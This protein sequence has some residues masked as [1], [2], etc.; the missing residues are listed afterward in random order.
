MSDIER[1]KTILIATNNPGKAREIEAV[2][3]E[4]AGGGRLD[5]VRWLTL[6]DLGAAIEEPHEDQATFEGNSALKATYYSKASGY[7]TLA[8][9]SGLEVDALDGAPGVFSARYAD[10][11]GDPPRAERDL[12]NNRKMIAALTG[13]SDEARTARFRCVLTLADGDRVLAQASGAIE[14]RIIDAPRGDG[15][16]GYDPH[17][18]VPELGQTT[19]ELAAEHKNRISHR[20]VALRALRETLRG[21]LGEAS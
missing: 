15:G 20:G 13:V 16:F 12:A 9:D 1:L 2:L 3:S 6:R 4:N 17:F 10:V 19:A 7:V 14:G 18:L 8:D 5:E 21:M 11:E